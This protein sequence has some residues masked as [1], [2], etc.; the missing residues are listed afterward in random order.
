M[1]FPLQSNCAY[2]ELLRD[3]YGIP[4]VK[5]QPYSLYNLNTPRNGTWSLPMPGV[6][7]AND[8]TL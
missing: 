4:W 7:A 1:G 3:Q 5:V 6:D 2:G 8:P